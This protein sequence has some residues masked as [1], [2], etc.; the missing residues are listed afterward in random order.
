MGP[1]RFVAL[2]IAGGLIAQGVVLAFDPGL[3][4]LPVG[5][6]GA[7]AA[8]IGGYLLL[9]P[10]TRVLALV[11]I[12]FFFGVLE[13]P[14]LVMLAAWVAMQAVFAATG[15]IGGGTAAYLCYLGGFAFGLVSIRGLVT[16]RKPVP[17]TAAAYR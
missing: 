9:Y 6:A 3:S 12:P 7:V 4:Q 15:L 2:Y 16:R 13:I 5:A 8:V 17:P 11:V 14:P 10:R 1:V